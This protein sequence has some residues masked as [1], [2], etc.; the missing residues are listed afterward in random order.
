M[1][2][3]IV[4]TL[5]PQTPDHTGNASFWGSD[6]TTFKPIPWLRVIAGLTAMSFEGR[7]VRHGDEIRIIVCF[8]THATERY[9][10]DGKLYGTEE[11]QKTG[12]HLHRVYSA[13][14][15]AECSDPRLP[16]MNQIRQV[17]EHEILESL[18]VIDGSG[19]RQ[20]FW[21]RE[22]DGLHGDNTAKAEL[23]ESRLPADAIMVARQ[24]RKAKVLSHGES[25]LHQKPIAY[26]SL[27][28]KADRAAA[29][30]KP[31]AFVP[32]ERA[33]KALAAFDD[34]ADAFKRYTSSVDPL[35]HY[36]RE[37][38]RQSQAPQHVET[39]EDLE[40]RYGVLAKPLDIVEKPTI[41]ETAKILA[42]IVKQRAT[43]P[44]AERPTIIPVFPDDL[45]RKVNVSEPG[46]TST[47]L[48]DHV[49]KYHAGNRR[50][51][52]EVS[53]QARAY[54]PIDD[55]STRLP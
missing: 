22:L 13:K 39:R 10:R 47:T 45:F 40:R 19:S 44:G 17:A 42:T 37:W 32:G 21:R 20:P 34:V 11:P 43:L 38:A 9:D 26:P 51:S 18:Q 50:R 4:D 29:L 2:S 23:L 8:K 46:I 24:E 6:Y 30:P 16:V 15:L 35:E 49:R 52:W 7:Y 12:L 3:A 55:M 31:P 48:A 14:D 41:E 54:A 36:F 25:P 1:T 53:T 33:R 5:F 28:S 27:P